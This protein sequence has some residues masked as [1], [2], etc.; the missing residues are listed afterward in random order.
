MSI[1]IPLSPE[2]VAELER[3]ATAAGLDVNAFVL[4]AVYEKLADEEAVPSPLAYEQWLTEFR[5]WVSS[6]S[7]RNPNFDDSRDSI[8]D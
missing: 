5:R 8:Y 1:T 4:D 6:H 7:S 2:A 3:R